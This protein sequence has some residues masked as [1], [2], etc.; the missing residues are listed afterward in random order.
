[1]NEVT[2][3]EGSN[4]TISEIQSHTSAVQR[5]IAFWKASLA[6][7]RGE[8]RVVLFNAT[9]ANA[10]V[11]PLVPRK[12]FV[13]QGMLD[14]LSLTEDELGL[15]LAHEVSHLILDHT[16]NS[17]SLE[18]FLN[19]AYLV[20]LT[21][22]GADF[23]LLTEFIKPAL[24]STLMAANSREHE[25]EADWLGMMIAS[26]SCVDVDKGAYVMKK[27][28][29]A[30][31]AAGKTKGGWVDT[32]PLSID[33]YKALLGLAREIKN[34]PAD[35]NPRYDNTTCSNLTRRLFSLGRA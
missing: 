4:F 34:S 25:S 2:A 32:H 8:W 28:S 19:M 20:I 18:N 1:M 16:H 35:Y 14:T 12:I 22:I 31:V 9:A 13:T 33:R 15:I 26:R 24:T 6:K 17:T 11:T 27:L 30:E 10:F 23:L 7:L 29:D 3:A 5:E 21:S